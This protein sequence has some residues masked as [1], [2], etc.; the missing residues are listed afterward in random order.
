[1]TKESLDKDGENSKASALNEDNLKIKNHVYML[2][3]WRGS[4]CTIC[5]FCYISKSQV[6]V[7]VKCISDIEKA[8]SIYKSLIGSTVFK[9]ILIINVNVMISNK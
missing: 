4:S 3:N 1:M 8:N 2:F 7:L 5:R 6:F 9:L